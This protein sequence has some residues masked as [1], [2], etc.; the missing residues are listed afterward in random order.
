MSMNTV[1]VYSTGPACQRCRLTHECL[2]AAGIPHAVI[3]LTI[4][5]NAAA[6]EYVM[7]DLGYTEAPVVVVDDHDHW[8]GFRPDLIRRL[9]DRLE[10][11][12]H[13]R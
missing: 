6:R 8:S 7:S 2:E 10:S 12:V 11:G 13:V 1:T 4:E 5:S 3:D 9:A